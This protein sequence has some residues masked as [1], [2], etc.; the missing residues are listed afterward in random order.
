MGLQPLATPLAFE[1]TN[2]PTVNERL[3]LMKTYREE[4][5]QA[6]K[7]TQNRIAQRIKANFRPFLIGDKVWL[8][9]QNLRMKINSKLKPKKEGPFE[10][11]KPI[12]KV[13]Y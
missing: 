11:E 8:D 9:T 5:L 3:Q 4:A 10:I 13:S 12:G 7:I 1:E 2:L 6:H